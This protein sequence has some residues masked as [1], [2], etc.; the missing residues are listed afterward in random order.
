MY[1]TL[2]RNN[3]VYTYEPSIE[4]FKNV[5]SSRIKKSSCFLHFLIIV[6]AKNLFLFMERKYFD[7]RRENMYIRAKQ[8]RIIIT[9]E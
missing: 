4:K 5:I 3:R 9:T 2:N 6:M 7:S 8:N 1:R